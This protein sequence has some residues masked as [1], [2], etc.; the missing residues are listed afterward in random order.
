MLRFVHSYIFH[1]QM[2]F[3]QQI[4]V[5]K[6]LIHITIPSE[7]CFVYLKIIIIRGSKL[8]FAKVI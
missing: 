6:K 8:L 5:K 1:L 2:H 4:D 7:K 3:N